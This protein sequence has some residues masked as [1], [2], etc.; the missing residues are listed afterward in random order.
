MLHSSSFP[1]LHLRKTLHEFQ[2]TTFS[3]I[4]LFHP[5]PFFYLTPN[6]RALFIT[7]TLL[8]AWLV[9]CCYLKCVYGAL[10]L[11]TKMELGPQYCLLLAL[12]VYHSIV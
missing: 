2:A 6:L 1:L 12:V 4:N 11:M 10:T 9:G 3:P 7:S 8:M 5:F